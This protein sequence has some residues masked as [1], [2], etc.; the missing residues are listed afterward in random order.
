MPKVMF[1]FGGE[2]DDVLSIYWLRQL[3]GYGVVA[4]LADVGQGEE[5]E[6]L[7]ELALECGAERTLIVDLKRR[8]VERFVFPT[9]NSG[10]QYEN[11]LLSTPL[12]RYAICEELV[13]QCHESEIEC[14]GH[15]ASAHGN[16]QIRFETSVSALDNKL[17]VI[18]PLRSRTFRSQEEKLKDLR[19]F[20][21]PERPKF[22]SSVSHDRNLWGCGSAHGDLGDPWQSPPASVY[23]LTRDP[24][25]APDVPLELTLTFRRGIPKAIDDV[26]ISAVEL[27]ERV[28]ELGGDH[29]VGR[30][31]HM[32]NRLVGGKTR[33]VYEA[34]AATILYIAH[35]ALE[36]LNQSRDL[37]RYKRLIAEEYGRLVYE[38]LWFSELREALDRFFE[39]T[40]RYVSGRVRVRLFKGHC[41]VIG[42]ESSFA[43]YDALSVESEERRSRLQDLSRGFVD[44]LADPARSEA[45][46]HNEPGER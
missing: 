25:S 7:G 27:V 41:T 32:E 19:R 46:H 13:R 17:E 33:E 37:N 12:S 8:F 10:A 39:S 40:Q 15:A 35:N 44:L 45:R 3:R 28:N 4:L 2:I 11:Y 16:D 1:A 22:R 38:G 21:L 31:D 42:R 6:R 29:G 9:L 18:N 26:E 23:Q 5:L 43:L 20:R 14:I 30:L 24:Q 36:E 34:P